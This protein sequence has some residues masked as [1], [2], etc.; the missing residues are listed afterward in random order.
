MRGE[1]IV[2]ADTMVAMANAT[3]AREASRRLLGE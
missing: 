1:F 2:T 3:G